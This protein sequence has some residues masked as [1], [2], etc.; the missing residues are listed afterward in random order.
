MKHRT[1][2][3]YCPGGAMY[4]ILPMARG[5]AHIFCVIKLFSWTFC[6]HTTPPRQ[7]RRGGRGKRVMVG[8]LTP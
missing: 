5:G 3:V 7:K 6:S 2:S 1:V 8:R 4:E